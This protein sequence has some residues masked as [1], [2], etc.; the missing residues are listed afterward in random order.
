MTTS[1]PES[2]RISLS[3]SSGDQRGENRRELHALHCRGPSSPPPPSSGTTPTAA[4]SLVLIHGAD[5]RLQ[6]AAHWKPHF[7]FLEKH[8]RVFAV[9]MLGHGSSH[10]GES[11]PLPNGV[12]R[13]DIAEQIQALTKLIEFDVQKQQAKTMSIS[14]DGGHSL[15]EKRYILVGRS[16]G[17]GVS[18]RLAQ[19]IASGQIRGAKL[20]GLVLIAPFTEQATIESLPK[21]LPVLAVWSEEDRIIPPQKGL[22]LLRSHFDNLQ[23]LMFGEGQILTDAV[24]KRGE[25]WRSHTPE[26]EKPTEFHAAMERFLS[27]LI[28]GNHH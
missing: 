18:A 2:I 9:D 10:P 3:S 13:I 7:P 23:V 12:T 6:N 28:E 20:E 5:R 25:M 26:N 22:H 21:S 8:C 24:L 19:Q 14:D 11:D 16:Y 17:G 27:T 15:V 1:V 4:H